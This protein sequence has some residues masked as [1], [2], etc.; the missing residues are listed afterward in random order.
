MQDSSFGRLVGVLVS[1]GKTFEEIAGKPTWL[2]AMVAL[3]IVGLITGTLISGKIDFEETIRQSLDEQGRQLG[4]E[5]TQQAIDIGEKVARVMTVVSPL[6]FQPIIYLLL[7]LVFMVLF[8]VLGGELGF[9]KSLAVI[10]HGMMPRLVL[11]LLSIPVILG[12]AEFTAEELQSGG[13]MGSNVGYFLGED[14]GPGLLALMSSLDVFS[15]WTV[16]LL[17][18]G[19]AA[20][21]RISKG[22]AAGGVAGLWVLYVLGKVGISMLRG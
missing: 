10:V 8:R 12:R 17:I 19:F 2:V 11:G 20:A 15:I 4:E 6:V 9:V 16:V 14:T 7:A 21:A 5:Q 13:V 1:P 22:T 18:I 3:I